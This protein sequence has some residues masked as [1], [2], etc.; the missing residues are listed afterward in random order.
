MSATDEPGLWQAYR[1]TG[2]R[3]AQHALFLQYIPWARAVARDVYRRVRIVQMDWADY[4]QNATVGLLEAMGRFDPLRGIDFPAYAKPRVRGAVFNG[5][6][7]FLAEN[8]QTRVSASQQ[9]AER[10]TSID[11]DDHDDPLL[12]MVATVTGLGLGFLLDSLA[13]R[14]H[15]AMDAD[16]SQIVENEQIQT[17]LRQVVGQL[18]DRQRLVVE[19]H[20]FQ[21][22]PFVE[23]AKLLGLTKGRI[24]QIHRAAIEDCAALLEAAESRTGG[25]Y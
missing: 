15:L 21:H 19:L 7:C 12:Q 13:S 9:A 18:R 8:Y 2:D 17:L 4:A 24:S 10:L 22:L 16:P 3:E 23:I 1:A 20:Y 11:S 5:L 6:R 25:I 14:D